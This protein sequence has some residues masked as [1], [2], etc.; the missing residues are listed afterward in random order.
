MK[1]NKKTVFVGMSGGVDSSV[2]AA[3]LK[4]AGY[5]VVGVFMKVWSP[6]WM[7]CIWPEER[8]DAMR[9]AAV[10][11]IP[12]LTFDFEKEYKEAVIDYMISEY[13]AGR[14]PNPDVM[15][16]RE[17]K[18][19]VFLKKAREMG[20]DFV[21]TGHYAQRIDVDGRAQMHVANDANKD[22]SY[23]LWTIGQEELSHT[24]FPIG[25]LQ[26]SEVRA[27]AKKFGLPVATKK[28]SQ[29]LCFVGH[30]DMKD[31]LKRYIDV[32]PGDVVNEKGK[33]IGTHDGALLYTIGERHGFTITHKTPDD[34][35]YYI[36]AK[37]HAK[38]ILIVS[39]D[40]LGEKPQHEIDLRDVRFVDGVPPDLSQKYTA[41]IRYRAA[42]ESCRLEK[43]G[44]SFQ[45]IFEK[46]VRSV[47]S[48]QSLVLYDGDLCLG[49]GII[50]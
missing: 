37:D 40:S 48:G 32:V 29:G 18:F 5:D 23:F 28:D 45:V 8:R 20:A 49:G 39:H 34:A 6:D 26:K 41:R 30:V 14:T 3:L 42:L 38:N 50:M 4:E 7:P 12:L 36:V 1:L 25:H 35:P 15:C 24:F 10:L 46:S 44:D 33:V 9:V 19:G 13:K 27:L 11:D 17:I 22:Q 43:R 47:T 2:S 21:A 31:F 16:N